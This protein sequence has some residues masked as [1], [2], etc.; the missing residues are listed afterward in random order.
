MKIVLIALTVILEFAHACP[1]CW[2]NYEGGVGFDFKKGN[3]PRNEN[4]D[5][6]LDSKNE[7]KLF[8]D[9]N[10]G[11]KVACEQLSKMEKTKSNPVSP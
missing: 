10:R 11:I 5:K 1:R 3:Y 4:Y 7:M 9:C 6:N 2:E 8:A